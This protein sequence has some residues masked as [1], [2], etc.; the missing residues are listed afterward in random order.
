MY[1][2]FSYNKKFFVEVGGGSDLEFIVPGRS[3]S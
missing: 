2:H 3:S 1:C